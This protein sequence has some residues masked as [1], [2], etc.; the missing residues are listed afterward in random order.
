MRA[1]ITKLHLYPVK[2][3]QG[4]EVTEISCLETGVEYD[5]EWVVVDQKNMFLTQRQ[6]PALASIK[7]ALTHDNLVLSHPGIE[8]INIPLNKEHPKN[9]AAIQFTIW[10]DQSMG[11]DEGPEVSAWLSEVLGN[12]KGAP[13]RLLRYDQNHKRMVREKY[14]DN[15]EAHFKFADACPYLIV[16]EASLDSL[17][18]TLRTNGHNHVTMDRFRGNIQ[19]TGIDAWQEY[20]CQTLN[21]QHISLQGEGPC[22]RCPMTGINQMTGENKEPGQPLQTLMKLDSPSEKPGGYFGMHATFITGSGMTLK[23]GEIL[24]LR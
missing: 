9:S 4:I 22:M 5:R 7:V 20:E 13:L 17:N 12:Y 24:E 3:M 1:T 14:T 15:T 8:S 21:T 11:L 19:I 10:K 23:V 2:S 6:I 16:N 18:E